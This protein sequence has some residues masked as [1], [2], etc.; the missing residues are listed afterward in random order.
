L[1]FRFLCR[2]EVLTQLIPFRRVDSVARRD[3]FV[4]R[5]L[6]TELIEFPLI[7][8]PFAGVVLQ[9]HA[10]RE[11][12]QQQARNREPLVQGVDFVKPVVSLFNVPGRNLF[13]GRW[14]WRLG[15]AAAVGSFAAHIY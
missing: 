7:A 13:C 11:H 5:R 10:N 4:T 14:N 8:F 9:D 6:D 3:D 2:R 1:L 15:G 12:K